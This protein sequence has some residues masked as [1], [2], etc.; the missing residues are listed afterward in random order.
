M[1]YNEL[2]AEAFYL[3]AIVYDKLGQLEEREEA[4]ASFKKHVIALQNPQDEDD[5][6]VK[7]GYDRIT[8]CGPNPTEPTR[9]IDTLKSSDPM[10]RQLNRI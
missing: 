1:Q 6:H 9:N 3:M 8:L 5:L 4:A 2:A 7:S 10:D